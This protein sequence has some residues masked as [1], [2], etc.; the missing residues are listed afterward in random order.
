MSDRLKKIY[1]K[2]NFEDF[3]RSEICQ[4]LFLVEKKKKKKDKYFF[5]KDETKKKGQNENDII[6]AKVNAMHVTNIFSF[7]FFALYCIMY[8]KWMKWW[9][10]REQKDKTEIIQKFK[11]M[12]NEQFRVWILNECKWKHKITKDDI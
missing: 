12:S 1:A 6:F 8:E 9:N 2:C 11:T 4:V 3:L 7:V 5:D 10:E